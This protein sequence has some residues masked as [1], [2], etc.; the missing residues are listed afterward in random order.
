MFIEQHQPRNG[1]FRR[2]VT[3]ALM[4]CFI[5]GN[6]MLPAPVYGADPGAGAEGLPVPGVRV[7]PSPAY[8]PVLVKGMTVYPDEPFHF[9]FIMESGDASIS[10]EGIRHE[11][12]KMAK[13]F[14]TSLTV[15]QVDLW[16]NLS[17]YE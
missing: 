8:H 16:V 6:V 9:E 14:L 11:A 7:A 12:Q 4:V 3:V 17:P 10:R 5:T 15:P 2:I 13:Y 1:I